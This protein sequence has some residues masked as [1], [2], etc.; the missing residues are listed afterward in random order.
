MLDEGQFNT[1]CHTLG[2]SIFTLI[3]GYYYVVADQKQEKRE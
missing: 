2:V 1:L 3:I